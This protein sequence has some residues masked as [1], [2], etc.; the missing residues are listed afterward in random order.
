VTARDLTVS[1]V[2]ATIDAATDG[3][4]VCLPAGSATWATQ[5]NVTNKYITIRGA[6]SANDGTGTVITDGVTK[7]SASPFLIRWV[8]IAGGLS[9]ITNMRL[10]GNAGSDSNNR[11]MM[12]FAGVSDQFRLDNCYMTMGTGTLFQIQGYVRGVV[13]HNTFDLTSSGSTVASYVHHPAWADATDTNGDESWHLAHTMGTAEAVYYEDNTAIR[14]A[15]QTNRWM[16]DGWKGGRSVV[17]YNTLN[18]CSVANHGTESAGRI[19]GN[20]QQE[21][22]GNT[23]AFD[24]ITTSSVYGTRGGTGMV[25]ENT[26]TTAN[27]T[28]SRVFD[29]QNDR[30]IDSSNQWITLFTPWATAAIDSVASITRSGTTATV[31]CAQTLPHGLIAQN[32]TKVEIS[33]ANESD[34]NG[35][36]TITGPALQTVSTLVRSGTTLTVTTASA[37]PF[38]AGDWVN[39]RGSAAGV[40]AKWWQVATVIDTTTFTITVPASGSTPITSGVTYLDQTRFTYTVSG[41]P[42]TPATGTITKRQPWDGNTD[43]YG[44]RCM[45]QPGAG[46]GVRLTNDNPTPVGPVGNALEP[47]YSWLNTKDGANSAAVTNKPN[48]I[49]ADRDFYDYVSSGF[50]GT[51]GVGVGLLAARPTSGL[52]AGVGYWATDTRTLYVATGATTWTTYYTPYTYPHPLTEL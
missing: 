50:D 34:Y 42:S 48:V 1:E 32:N 23:F 33:G 28:V 14:N 30:S 43:A 46:A 4:V 45:D 24:G 44:Y 5:V 16:I 12:S 35:S 6:G 49:V 38:S 2:Q 47:V 3:Q 7:S 52:V 40:Y 13:D 25:F 11:G 21:V 37:H 27:G 8:T 17:R 19:R 22:Y 39:L 20:R 31:T 36:F 51:S 15:G 9:R 26:L 29:L 10:I 41:S 18:N